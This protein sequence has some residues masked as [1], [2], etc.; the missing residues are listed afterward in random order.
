MTNFY[1]QADMDDNCPAFTVV[2]RH[3]RVNVTLNV[4]ERRRSL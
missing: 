4:N 3:Q 2:N 1:E